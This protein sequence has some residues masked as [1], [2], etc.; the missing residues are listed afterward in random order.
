[1]VIKEE[2]IKI[3]GMIYLLCEKNIV[4]KLNLQDQKQF[5]WNYFN[6]ATR[7]C[8]AKDAKTGSWPSQP[9]ESCISAKTTARHLRAF[10]SCA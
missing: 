2:N 1:M 8:R 7:V 3:S 5:Q 4:E 6:I 10:T 9:L